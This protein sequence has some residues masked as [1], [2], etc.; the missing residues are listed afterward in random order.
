MKFILH[1]LSGRIETVEG[2]DIASA[3]TKAGYGAGAIAA[4]DYFDEACES[5][6]VPGCVGCQHD[7]MR[8]HYAGIHLCFGPSYRPSTKKNGEQVWKDWVRQNLPKQE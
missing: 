7:G 6:F 3:F 4:L 5:T 8:E 2:K 1:W